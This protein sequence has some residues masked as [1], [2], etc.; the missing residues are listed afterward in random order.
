MIFLLINI[1]NLVTLWQ[2]INLFQQIDKFDLIVFQLQNSEDVLFSSYLDI[3]TKHLYPEFYSP[4]H[5]INYTDILT[6]TKVDY[7]DFAA[8]ISTVMSGIDPGFN[9]DFF[10]I[11]NTDICELISREVST[12]EGEKCRTGSRL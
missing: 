12:Q 7:V 5:E 6:Q 3:K 2:T 4:N 9:S 8:Q 1:P 11:L 10:S